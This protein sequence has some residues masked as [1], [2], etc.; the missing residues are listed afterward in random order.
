M[1]VKVDSGRVQEVGA[2]FDITF[3]HIIICYELPKE[4]LWNCDL[5]LINSSKIRGRIF[6]L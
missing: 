4:H 3:G 5:Q 1:N 2:L 6:P